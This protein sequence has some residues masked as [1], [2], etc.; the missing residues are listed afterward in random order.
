MSSNRIISVFASATAIAGL[1]SA[2]T[3]GAPSAR[4]GVTAGGLYTVIAYSPISGYTGWANNGAMIGG[5]WMSLD[6]VA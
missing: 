1:F 3:A 5:L 4:A 2:A 6:E